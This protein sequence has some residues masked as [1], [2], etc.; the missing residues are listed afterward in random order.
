MTQRFNDFIN[1]VL[2]HEGGSYENDPDDP[3]G[4][5]RWG[6]DHRSHPDVDIKNLTKDEATQIY[7]DSYWT[8]NKCESLKT[9]LGESHMDAC[10]NCGSGRAKRFLTAADGSASKYN[11]Q[12]SAFYKRLVEARPSSAKYLKGWENRV[13]DLRKWISPVTD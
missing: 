7:F 12:R 11:D 9:G 4:P 13:Q 8:P 10:V 5:T 1:F 6:I 2:A 3:G